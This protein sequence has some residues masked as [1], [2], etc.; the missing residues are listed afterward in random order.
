MLK[1][2]C[3]WYQLQ[4]KCT[5]RISNTWSSSIEYTSL[6][7]TWSCKDSN[8]PCPAL[9]CCSHVS[10]HSISMQLHRILNAVTSVD[11]GV[12]RSLHRKSSFLIIGLWVGQ[13][14]GIL[15]CFIAYACTGK[16]A[17]SKCPESILQKACC[18][19]LTL[20]VYYTNLQHPCASY[21]LTTLYVYKSIYVHVCVIKQNNCMSVQLQVC[22]CDCACIASIQKSMTV[23]LLVNLISLQQ[24]QPQTKKIRERRKR[25]SS[26]GLRSKQRTESATFKKW[27]F[28]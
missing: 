4:I 27:I 13:R 2:I 25:V 21:L 19:P 9:Q 18:R 28:S 11:T 1:L 8:K 17:S 3:D 16:H 6:D 26:Q 7:T 20:M 15:Q 14:A 22:M 24:P 12:V 10:A 23:S 5:R